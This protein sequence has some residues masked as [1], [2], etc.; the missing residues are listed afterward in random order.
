MRVLVVVDGL[1]STRQINADHGET[2]ERAIELISS[3]EPHVVDVVGES[4]VAATFAGLSESSYDALVFTSNSLRH[5]DGA[6]AKAEREHTDQIGLFLESGR[7]VVI[8][9]QFRLGSGSLAWL[10]SDSRVFRERS[11]KGAATDLEPARDD[12]IWNFPFPIDDVGMELSREGQLGQTMSWLAVADDEIHQFKSVLRLGNETMIAKS[13]RP[14]RGRVLVCAIPLDWHKST[15]LL[16]NC[17]AFASQG[18]PRQVVWTTSGR[19]GALAV[20]NGAISARGDAAAIDDAVNLAWLRSQSAIHVAD[21]VDDV[22]IDQ[23]RR[24]LGAG[25]VVLAA[26]PPDGSGVVRFSG[27]VGHRSLL[28]AGDFWSM[29]PG[30]V[31]GEGPPLDPFPL[32]NLLLAGRYFASVDPHGT[33]TWDPR[34]DRRVSV[35]L[36]SAIY[37][38]IT[39]TSLLALAQACAASASDPKLTGQVLAELRSLSDVTEN[40]PLLKA[41]E[42]A[43]GQGDFD[44]FVT[45]TEYALRT[46]LPA[47]RALRILDWFGFLVLVGH[48]RVDCRLSDIINRLVHMTA[49]VEQD[50]VWLS[51][52]GSTAVLQAAAAGAAVASENRILDRLELTARRIQREVDARYSSSGYHVPTLGRSLMTLAAL[53]SVNPQ[54][55]PTLAEHIGEGA[56]RSTP[57]MLRRRLIELSEE[58]RAQQ[59]R[60]RDLVL[61]WNQ[62]RPVRW[63]GGAAIWLLSV[64]LVSASG[65]LALQ[66]LSIEGP[67]E[68]AAVAVFAIAAI[69][70]IALVLVILR[71]LSRWGL[72]HRRLKRPAEVLDRILSA[73]LNL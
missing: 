33:G 60:E 23:L 32:R 42:C 4:R 1:E 44:D 69:L 41:A 57:T 37:P 17:V 6:V 47:P 54:V 64:A 48:E 49:P 72:V 12:Q 30:R 68:D 10:R 43:L 16:A 24:S 27:A 73:R 67:L 40:L 29:N 21:R 20:P 45:S 65:W 66:L 35:A 61:A 2:V 26:N 13:E 8:L 5:N 28:Y 39:A 31:L 56:G 7:G 70:W 22:R 11:R 53:E 62:S 36:K 15:H 50:G 46:P 25:G 55:I 14:D 58:S 52:E 38:G 51:L 19:P 71:Q 59:V 9:H 34:E 63:A 3:E 18:Q